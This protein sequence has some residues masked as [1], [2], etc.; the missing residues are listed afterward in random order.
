MYNFVLIRTYRKEDEPFC[1]KLLKAGVMDQL[2][3]TFIG[4]L[5]RKPVFISM[6]IVILLI[7]IISL[8]KGFSVV[9]CLMFIFILP[10]FLYICLYVS[11]FNEAKDMEKEVSAISRIYMS[12]NSSHFWVAESYEFYLLNRH[13]RHEQRT[14][15]T[16]E[17][18]NKS[19]IDVSRHKKKVVGTIA[20][21]KSYK[22]PN[23]AWITRLCVHKDYRRKRIGTHLVNRALQFGT[24]QGF[25]TVN[26]V[27][28]EYRLAAL[29]L[30]YN[31]GFHRYLIRGRSY[32]A[33]VVFHELS[34]RTKYFKPNELYVKS[35]YK[36]K[37]V[38]N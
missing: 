35:P 3:A 37:S 27:I 18:F 6:N 14:F 5:L 29:K 17:E 20:L 9:Y 28:S 7:S 22:I 4:Y 12:D 36:V 1:K 23:G 26:V 33:S 15:M 38:R 16:E 31:R 13:Q 10:I 24:E 21:Y 32:N 11:F 19:N 8:L 30:F 34:Y 25:I 2:N